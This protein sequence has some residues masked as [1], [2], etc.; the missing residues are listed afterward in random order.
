M[1]F[2]P[3]TKDRQP[4]LTLRLYKRHILLIIII[5][6]AAMFAYAAYF[7]F[8]MTLPQSAINIVQEVPFSL[9]NQRI[10]VVSPHC[11]DETLGASGLMQIAKREGSEIKIIMVTDCNYQKIGVTRR[12]ETASALK[13]IG[14]NE[15]NIKFLNFP[16]KNEKSKEGPEEE[17]SMKTAILDEVT[18]YNPTLIIS[19]HSQDTHIDHATAGQIIQEIVKGKEDSIKVAYYLI[20]YNFLRYPSPPGLKPDEFLLPPARLISLTDRWYK[21]DLPSEDEDVKEEATLKYKSQLHRTNPILH[22]ILLDFVRRN[23]LFMVRS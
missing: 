5:I 15:N 17:R 6:V 8:F 18:S 14:F 2:L 22:R 16:E 19:P 12:A 11:D 3:S 1:K 4:V 23:E 21:L 13:T 7:K 10:L 9:A 20:H